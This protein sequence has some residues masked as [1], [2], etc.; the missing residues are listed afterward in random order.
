[1]GRDFKAPPKD[2]YR[3]WQ[4]LRRLYKVG[5]A[6]HSCGCGGPGLVP[7]TAEELVSHLT[8]QLSGYVEQLRYWLIRSA[9]ITKIEHEADKKENWHQNWGLQKDDKGRVDAPAALAYWQ[10]RVQQLEHH[11]AE[12]KRQLPTPAR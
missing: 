11:I 7:A 6:F 2:D 4:H 1:M 12:V 5:I 9:P 10:G 3:A 8:Q